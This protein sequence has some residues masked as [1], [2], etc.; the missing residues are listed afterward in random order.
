LL[1]VLRAS[2]IV[3]LYLT[4]L[5]LFGVG[6]LCLLPAPHP[7]RTL[8]ILGIVLATFSYLSLL[9][10]FFPLDQE[11]KTRYCA[12]CTDEKR[13]LRFLLYLA[14]GMYLL[15]GAWFWYLSTL[16]SLAPEGVVEIQG[17][18]ASLGLNGTS[19]RSLKITLAG[20]SNEYEIP[21]YRVAHDRLDD[22][23]REL[24]PG[25]DVHLTIPRGEQAAV[26]DAYIQIFAIR[27]G[28]LTYLSLDEYRRSDAANRKILGGVGIVLTGIGLA[29][30]FSGR[31]AVG[32][33]EQLQAAPAQAAH[34]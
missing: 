24:R 20:L 23:L 7:N 10:M 4:G 12:G 9:V 28:A 19:N 17:K 25:M 30:L 3:R 18:I 32:K 2:K 11:I 14:R 29:F 21:T 26:D 33:M 16:S 13:A 5:G 31:Q 15:I 34:R 1:S 27:K 6:I 8:G 22:I